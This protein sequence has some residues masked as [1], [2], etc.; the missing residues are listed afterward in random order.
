MKRFRSARRALGDLDAESAGRLAT[1]AADVTLI[2]DSKGTIRDVAFGSDELAKEFGDGEGWVGSSWASIVAPET[3]P[4]IE[5]LMTDASRGD[6]LRWRQVNHP[7]AQGQDVPILYCTAP[8]G[9][10]GKIAAFGRDLRSI[11]ALQ[12]RLM[13]LQQSIERD[14]ARLRHAETRYRLLFQLGVEAL[15]IADSGSQ[16]I[17]EANPAAEKLFGEKGRTIVGR[18]FPLAADPAG[19]DAMQAQLANVRATGRAEDIQIRLAEGKPELTVSAILFRQENTALFLVRAAASPNDMPAD[20]AGH[21]PRGLLLKAAEA[22]Q[23]AMVVTDTDGR[24]LTANH[25]FLELAQIMTED[26][27]QGESLERWLG[28]PGVDMNVL[29]TNLRQHGSLRSFATT[30]RGEH[31]VTADIDIAAVLLPGDDRPAFGFTL[32]NTT[33]RSAVEPGVARELPRSVS[34]MSELVGRVALKDL[35]R[36]ATDVIER[37]C[38]EAALELTSDN[39]ASAAEMLG[40]SRQSLYVKLRRYGLGDLGTEDLTT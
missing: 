40:L 19:T 11:S 4:K 33:K 2:L 1:A 39:R 9:S 22:S 18:T 28:R 37:L 24:I 38:I 31:G 35:V 10:S 16:K 23:D 25:A 20:R 26:Q 13:D 8:F 14:Y 7:S 12:Q 36:E 17:L 21:G 3:R 27:A 30:L 5:S 15:V 6:V 34:Q 32:R 29:I